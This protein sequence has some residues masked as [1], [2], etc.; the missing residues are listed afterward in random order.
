MDKIIER[1]IQEDI[2]IQ[3]NTEL[4]KEEITQLHKNL[5]GIKSNLDDLKG[6]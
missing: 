2:I 4:E 5:N 6:I 3:R 1:K